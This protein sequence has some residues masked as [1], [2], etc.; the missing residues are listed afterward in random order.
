MNTYHEEAYQSSTC[1][2]LRL[3]GTLVCELMISLSSSPSH[4]TYAFRICRSFA[5][6]KS[7]SL[8]STNVLLPRPW[9]NAGDGW[10]FGLDDFTYFLLCT[11]PSTY[12]GR[13]AENL[14][15]SH[16]GCLVHFKL[17]RFLV[18]AYAQML[19]LSTCFSSSLSPSAGRSADG[20]FTRR[21]RFLLIFGSQ[22]VQH[23]REIMS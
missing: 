4:R 13:A 7:A 9:F 15:P 1:S 14:L 8:S 22:K 11:R 5:L 18:P 10:R 23:E 16:C 3:P 17:K 12:S 6:L 2:V 19:P 20:A 21:R